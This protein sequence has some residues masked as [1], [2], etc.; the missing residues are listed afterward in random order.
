[1]PGKTSRQDEAPEETV[2]ELIEEETRV[3]EFAI[4]MFA[5]MGYKGRLPD[6]VVSVYNEFK[7]RK[8]MIQP[9]RLSAEGFAYVA[10][11]GE[12]LSKVG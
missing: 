8:D 3:D 9:G 5:A 4:G 12:I 1:M 7:R 10:T 6:S 2:P 11:L